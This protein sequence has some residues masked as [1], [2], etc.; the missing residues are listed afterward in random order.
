MN[1]GSG[2]YRTVTLASGLP[3]VADVQAIDVD[4]D[5][6]LDLIVAA[7]G[8]RTSGGVFLLENR[9]VDYRSPVFVK[10]EIDGRCGAIHVPVADLNGDGFP[11]F[12]A[13]FAQHHEAVV[14]FLND[15]KGN[16][17][18]VTIDQ[19]PHPAWGSSGIEL[20]IRNESRLAT[21]HESSAVTSAWSFTGSGIPISTR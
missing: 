21:S 2:G 19:A 17:R 11:D 9:T 18:A 4:G 5:G 15:G 6:D 3:R 20:Q 12:A 10:R 7:F 1:N 14:A 16:F 13:L 8:W